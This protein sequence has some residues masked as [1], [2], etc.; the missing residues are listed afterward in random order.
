MMVHAVSKATPTTRLQALGEV[1]EYGAE[2]DAVQP[3][4]LAVDGG[5]APLHA[6]VG[7]RQRH[8]AH[9]DER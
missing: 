9:D 4:D 7:E 8:D 6:E 1:A 3:L 5:V 2:R